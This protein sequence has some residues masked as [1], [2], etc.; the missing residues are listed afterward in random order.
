MSHS[1]KPRAVIT[2]MGIVC[3]LGENPKDYF[4]NLIQGRSG[5]SRWK[6]MDNSCYSKIGGD[7]SAFSYAQH[8]E[9]Y[10]AHYPQRLKEIIAK[11]LRNTPFAGQVTL[12]AALQ[13]FVDSGIDINAVDTSRVAHIMGGHNLNE[14]FIFQNTKMYLEEPEYIE[15]L[16]GLTAL[17]T[18]VLAIINE[19]L[20]IHGPT[21]SVGGACSSSNLA[22]SAALDLIRLNKADVVVVSGA[23]SDL[24]PV[25]LQGW[26]FL[27]ALSYKTFNDNPEKASRPFDSLREG[28]LPSQAGAVIVLENLEYA[29]KRNAKIYGELL[30]A[31]CNS[32]ASRLTRPNQEGQHRAMKTALQDA[33]VNKEEIDYVNAHATST[34]LGDRVEVMA[35]KET[36]GDHAYHLL[37]NSTKSML[38]HCLL[39]ASL[40][41]CIAVLLQLSSGIIHPTIN[42]EHPDPELDLDFVPNTARERKIKIALS[43]SFGFGGINSSIILKKFGD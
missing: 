25:C 18:D 19:L 28:F 7:L 15:P 33:G 41:E 35:I 26:A 13:A 5:I 11:I 9:H 40:V 36:F 32:D 37:V 23:A 12:C 34:P 2:G 8:L 24:D 21:F 30:G 22:I 31:A 4:D 27:D 29:R 38:G 39:A 20:N 16:F 17:D 3:T 42:Q 14:G 10:G 6:N 1:T 43:N